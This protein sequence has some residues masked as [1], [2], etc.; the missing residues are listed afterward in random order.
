MHCVM[1]R[2]GDDFE[3]ARVVAL[4]ALDE[5]DAHARRQVRVF[6][7]SLLPASPSRVTED[8]DVRRPEGQPLVT[9]AIALTHELIILRTRLCRDNIGDP[10]HEIS[11]PSCGETD[12]LWENG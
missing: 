1:L 3:V 2:R 4:Q 5:S 8:V 7:V 11:I 10:L 9:P 12:G 6:A